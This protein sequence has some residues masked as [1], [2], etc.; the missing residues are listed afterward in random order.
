MLKHSLLA[1]LAA[2]LLSA[3]VETRF[4][5][6]LGDNIETCDPAWKGVWL[7]EG[8][9]GTRV[10][11]KQH[12]TGFNVDEGCALT[13]F[14]QPEAEGPLKYTRIPINFVHAH[15]KDYVVVTDVALRAVG[16]IPPP[17]GIEPVPAK[18]Y[19][20][21]RYRIRGDRLEL[22]GVDSKKL[23]RMVIDG[24]LD[25]TVQSTRN[26]LHVFVRGDRAA[27]LDLVRRHDVFENKPIYRMRRSAQSLE[28]LEESIERKA[29]QPQP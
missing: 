7:D 8:D 6:P 12:L 21:A 26:E 16:D 17:F 11:G 13:L 9:D 22:R 27:M 14:D 20:F 25:G 15:G 2:V 28:E 1:L 19:Y 5:S 18:S 24:V 4:E 29:T 3:C 10:D 23:A